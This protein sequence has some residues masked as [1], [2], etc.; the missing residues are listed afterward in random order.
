MIALPAAHSQRFEAISE[1]EASG[2]PQRRLRE[3]LN[4]ERYL[5]AI[6]N[7]FDGDRLCQRAIARSGSVRVTAASGH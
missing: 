7:R 5:R 1:P 4:G 6:A 3:K 2:W